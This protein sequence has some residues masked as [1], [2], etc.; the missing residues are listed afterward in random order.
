MSHENFQMLSALQ[1]RKNKRVVLKSVTRCKL[2]A[3]S[4]QSQALN[5]RRLQ[6]KELSREGS[7]GKEMGHLTSNSLSSQRISRGSEQRDENGRSKEENGK[8]NLTETKKRG[9]LAGKEPNGVQTKTRRNW[10]RL[11]RESVSNNSSHDQTTPWVQIGGKRSGE[12]VMEGEASKHKKVDEGK[13]NEIAMYE[14]VVG[15]EMMA[16]HEK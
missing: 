7:K 9:N 8:V 4:A 2:L 10:K 5:A 6:R 1:Q 13:S 15:P 16:H 3:A 12:P 14:S 11:A